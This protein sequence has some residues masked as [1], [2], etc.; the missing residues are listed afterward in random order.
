MKQAQPHDLC[1]A[2]QWALESASDPATAA[3]DWLARDIDP[4][5][6]SATDLLTSPRVTLK[7]LQQ[8]KNVYKTMRVLGETRADRRTGGRL[9]L[10]SIAAAIVVHNER[11]SRQSDAALARALEDMR[12]DDRVAYALRRLADS[13]LALIQ[14]RE[15]AEPLHGTAHRT[16]GS[17]HGKRNAELDEMDDTLPLE[18]ERTYLLDRLPPLPREADYIRIEQGYLPDSSSLN[19]RLRREVLSDGAVRF[20][21]TVKQGNGLVRTEVERVISQEEFDEHWPDT[22]GQ[23]LTKTRYFVKSGDFTWEVDV[24]D[25]LNL[26]LAEVELPTVA[27][28]PKPPP[29]LAPHIVRDVTHEKQYRNHQLALR[30]ARGEA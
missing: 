21:H 16:N 17:H 18:I 20:T 15:A 9:Y 8:A 7:Q 24:F 22:A 1:F 13:A 27:S 2:L 4:A 10:A 3:A 5:A 11:I 12:H 28:A 30:L 23:R 26:V 25:D 6:A 29:W 14:G 19:G